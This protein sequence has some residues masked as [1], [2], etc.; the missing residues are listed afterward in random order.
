MRESRTKIQTIRQGNTNAVRHGAYRK[1]NLLDQRTREARI[2]AQLEGML[3]S[4]LGGDP[5]PQQILLIKRACVKAFRCSLLERE[6][7]VNGGQVVPRIDEDY[8][9]W[10]RELRLDLQALGL[11]KRM[12]EVIDLKD[13]ISSGSASEK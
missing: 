13:Y 9:R 7:I 2:L 3:V 12:K 5:S 11:E 8:L 6:I 10:S 4:A 1:L